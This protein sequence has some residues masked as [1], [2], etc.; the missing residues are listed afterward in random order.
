MGLFWWIVLVGL[1]LWDI[2]VLIVVRRAYR[3]TRLS[4]RMNQAQVRT[5]GGLGTGFAVVEGNVV[6][7]DGLLEAPLTREPCV[8]YGVQVAVPGEFADIQ[9]SSTSIRF[10]LDDGTG[11]IELDPAELVWKG[12]ATLQH[13]EDAIPSLE[14]LERVRLLYPVLEGRSAG[15][16]LATSRMT[17]M[18]YILREGQSLCVAGHVVVT[19][20]KTQFVTENGKLKVIAALTRGESLEGLHS[21]A[22]WYWITAAVIAPI[23]VFGHILQLYGPALST[24]ATFG[25]LIIGAFALIWAA[26]FLS[27]RPSV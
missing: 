10:K 8:A 23:V 25:L 11:S 15:G 9:S 14:L 27:V 5:I 22:E 3:W 18:E 19:P 4:R 12:I 26:Y 17:C 13:E 20:E 24:S 7:L 16:D 6:A 2:V 1:F 21:T